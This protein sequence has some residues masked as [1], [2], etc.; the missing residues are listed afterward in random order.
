MRSRDDLLFQKYDL[1][2]VISS[3]RKAVA[4]GA[5]SLGKDE[6]LTTPVEAL[7]D[8]L[9][10]SHSLTVPALQVDKRFMDPPLET[11]IEVH[12]IFDGRVR[13]RGHRVTLRIPFEGEEVFFYCHPSTF[14]LSPPRALIEHGAVVLVREVRELDAETLKTSFDSEV[15]TIKQWLGW[16]AE[17]VTPFTNEL[18][19]L[20]RQAIEARREELSKAHNV[21]AAL[22]IPVRGGAE[23][24][25]RTLRP[26]RRD[27]FRPPPRRPRR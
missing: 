10:H 5:A 12:D 16:I 11:E 23:A 17:S 19:A 25:A 8:R 15:A 27:A 22:G 6:V 21:M 20:A 13:V 2:A 18:R 26:C 4:A 14:T 1:G 24:P 3:Q 9:V 7:E